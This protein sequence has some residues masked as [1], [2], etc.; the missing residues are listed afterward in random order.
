MPHTKLALAVT[1]ALGT[2]SIGGSM[3]YAYGE[4]NVT[5]LK[6]LEHSNSVPA[7]MCFTLSSRQVVS[8]EINNL[9]SFL[10]LKDAQGNVIDGTPSVVNESLCVSNLNNGGSYSLLFKQGLRF[11]SG[12]RLNENLEQKFTVSDAVAQIR[13]PYDIIL[14]KNGQNNS[15]T[16]KTINQPSV[17]LAI[18]RLPQ[19]YLATHNLEALFDNNLSFW[20]VHTIFNEAATPVYEKIFE[21]GSNKSVDVLS[22]NKLSEQSLHDIESSIDPKSLGEAGTGVEEQIDKLKAQVHDLQR[23]QLPSDKKNMAQELKVALKDFVPEQGSGAYLLIACDPRLDL[24][25]GIT[26]EMMNRSN[27][28]FTIKPLM[29]TDFGVS[30]YQ[31]S[32][33]ILLSVRSL[34]SAKSLEKVKVDL[35]AVNGET[36]ASATTNK[37]GVVRFNKEVV[38]GKNALAPSKIVV[39]NEHDYYVVDLNASPFYLEDNKGTLASSDYSAYAYTERGIYRPGETLHYTALV[40]NN[41]LQALNLPLTLKLTNNQGSEIHKV[42]LNNSLQGGYEYDFEI[43]K[44]T[45]NGRYLASLYLGEHLLNS[46][47]FTV[48]SYVPTQINSRFMDNESML[49]V[50]S[51]IKL[52]SQTNFNY[53]GAA[54]NLAGNFSITLKPD[55]KPIP[56]LANA[57]KNENLKLFH[58]GPDKSTYDKLIKTDVF[59]G[60]KTDV[61]GVLQTNVTL[62]G[63]D[64]PQKVSVLSQVFDTNGQSV[65]VNKDYKLAFNRPLV[66]VRMLEQQ[67]GDNNNAAF[68]LCSY[69]QDGSTFPQDVK[70]YLY[71]QFVDYNY[72]FED[73]VWRYVSFLSRNLVT[74]GSVKVDNQNLDKASIVAPLEDGS[75]V[76]ELESDKSTTTLNFIKGYVSSPDAS[77]PDRVMLYAN[78][79]SYKIGDTVTLSFDSPFKGYANLALGSRGIDEFKTF[80]IDKGHNEEEFVLTEDMAPQGHALL[81]IFSPLGSN[82]V[83]SLRAVGLCDINLDMSAHKFKVTTALPK[84]IKPQSK[85][86]V[87]V[88]ATPM[89]LNDEHVSLG[90]DAY[91]KVTLVDNGILSL[92]NYRSPDPNKTFMQD[93]KYDVSLRDP[94]GLIMTDPQQQGQGYGAADEAFMM[95]ATGAT[96][97]Q[98]IPSKSVALSSKIVPLNDLGEAQVE[99]DVPQFSGSLKVMAVAWDQDKTGS[100][101]QDVLVRD[102]AVAT[103][104]LPRYLNVGD[105]VQGRLNLHNLKA[106][107]P[108]FKVDISCSGAIKCSMQNVSSLKPGIREEKAFTITSMEPG[109]GKL[110]LTVI[111]P[112]FNLQDSYQL[113]VT[114]PQ[115]PMLKSYIEYLEPGKSVSYDLQGN[116]SAVD[117]ALIAWSQLPNVNPKAFVLNVDKASFGDLASLVASLE[118]KL[119]YGKA[120]IATPE[121]LKHDSSL[122]G[123]YL[124]RSE[125]EYNANIQE[126]IF[127]VLA[128]QLNDGSFMGYNQYNNI[129]AIDTLLKAQDQGYSVNDTAITKAIAYLRNSINYGNE[130]DAYAYEV[131]SRYESINQA[132]V[133]YLLDENKVKRP[134][135]L[136]NL[137]NALHNIGDDN[138]A[139]SALDNAVEG[140]QEWQRLED[141]LLK[142]YKDKEILNLLSQMEELAV[143]GYWNLRQASFSVIDSAL[144]LGRQDVVKSIINSISEVKTSPDYLSA[145]TMASML[146]ANSNLE[147]SHDQEKFLGSATLSND[148][149]K[150]LRMSSSDETAH[151]SSESMESAPSADAPA[152]NQGPAYEVSAG[153]LKVFNRS[154]EPVFATTSILGQYNQD[155]VISD[156]GFA[157]N[158]NYWTRSGAVD[159][160][161]YEFRQNEDVLME[162]FVDRSVASNS[163][164]VIKAKLPAGFE[165]VRTLVRNDPVFGSLFGEDD[166]I[167]SPQ[168]IASADD[169]VVATFN[170]Y[171]APNS[172]SLFLVLRAAHNGTFSQGQALVQLLSEPGRYGSTL[173]AEPI[174]ISVK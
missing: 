59:Y 126:L 134:M 156:K 121:Q 104:G 22:L 23:A 4:P 151:K 95:K 99:F 34:T 163:D 37:E 76:L 75:Y 29:I 69:L 14:P 42:L 72:V 118:S 130:V 74:Q 166:T 160:K 31:S 168:S 78:Q 68:A 167:Y 41:Q 140:L 117:G 165:Y 12:E 142:T 36:L 120:L 63:A 80:A 122:A 112:D 13:L 47:A 173:S 26:Y 27:L 55:S 30:T 146:R 44:G 82:K 90:G 58:F 153:H 105:S 19:E 62:N 170:R 98:T 65:S 137:A 133:R 103:I 172:F 149:L 77:S 97:L 144:R 89:S 136:A 88:A 73:G 3:S 92:T 20:S 66:G 53:G 148:D 71:K 60:L 52:R 161:N 45:T 159:L 115:L 6:Q 96:S 33:G 94:Y 64:Y 108:D 169:Q 124:Y 67:S 84:E 2:L 87:K 17:K 145:V 138:R 79:E 152:S 48:G 155:K 8:S 101:N 132:K 91:A 147:S 5:V 18:Y 157:V 100:T 39:S 125:A 54:S 107:N 16:I 49:A 11:V 51:Q 21:V 15:F 7:S 131:L 32:D 93:Q 162:I 119:L 158:V 154:S 50:N 61:Q 10:E 43:P 24:S 171:D 123:L 86:N 128:Q 106:K 40:R 35:R 143:N 127:R 102:N 109:I 57:A 116:F 110:N 129:Y 135:L 111:N 25:E 164:T 85:L 81:S 38:S 46:T 28:P 83:G 70:Y 9:K 141:K 114:S 1:L 150:T 139:N 56:S 113:A 174:K